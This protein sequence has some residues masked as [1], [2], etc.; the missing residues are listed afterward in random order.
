MNSAAIRFRVVILALSSAQ[1]RPHLKNCV[2]LCVSQYKRQK[3]V[4]DGIW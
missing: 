3:E 1:V 2:Q 4:V